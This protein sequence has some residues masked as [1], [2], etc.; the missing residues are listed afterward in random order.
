[1]L[2][3]FCS[4]YVFLGWNKP[5]PAHTLGYIY[6]PALLWVGIPMIVSSKLATH[7]RHQISEIWLNRLF[8]MLVILVGLIMLLQVLVHI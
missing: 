3:L 1:V 7:W 2:L 6:L 5:L 8:N 4:V